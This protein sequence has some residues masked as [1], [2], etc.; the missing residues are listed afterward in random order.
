VRF[1]KGVYNK[2][3]SLPRLQETWDV[4]V[5][6][7]YFKKLAPAKHLS[8]KD[9]TLKTVMLMAL[10]SAQR[11][12][13]LHMLSLENLD[14]SKSTY[15][16]GISAPLKTSRPGH[17]PPAL[18]F[19]A[20]APD[21][22]I[23]VYNYLRTYIDRT[24]KLRK[25]ETKLFISYRKPHKAVSRSTISR[26]IKEV[27]VRAGVKSTFTPHSTRSAA[28]SAADRA[29][30][31]V[32]DILKTAGWSSNKTFASYYNKPLQKKADFAAAILK[33]K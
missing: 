4:S 28:V 17:G 33:Q 22:R 25:K 10:V 18:E 29:K 23:C 1:L 16:F 14:I 9:L 31:P 5:V 6:L 20:Y 13:S 12:Q 3:P 32:E 21:K 8:L 15:K 2:R 30:V 11:G 27:M 26:W 7:N 19:K 24:K